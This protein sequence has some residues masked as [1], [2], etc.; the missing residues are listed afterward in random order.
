[1]TVLAFIKSLREDKNKRTISNKQIE[2]W[3]DSGAIVINGQR[4]KAKDLI[5]FPKNKDRKIT[6]L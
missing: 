5:E 4:P 2:R 6:M 1:M 3:L